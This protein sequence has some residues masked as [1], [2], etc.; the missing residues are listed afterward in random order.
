MTNKTVRTRF[1]P[2][3]TG[4]VHIGNFRTA[5]FAFLFARHNQGTFI[6]RIED[7]DQARL[8]EGALESLLTVLDQLGVHVD[9]GYYLQGG[10]VAEKGQHG[11]YLQSARLD[12][13]AKYGQELLDSGSAYYCFCTAE[14]LEEVRKEQMALKQPPMYD[15]HCRKLSAEQVTEQL[16]AFSKAGKKPVIRQAI[17]QEGS[18]TYDD[19]I[20]GKITIENS[21]LDDQVLLKSDGYPTYHM[22]VVIDDHLMEITHTIRGQEYL[23][24]TPKHV[25]LYDALGWEVPTFAH[26]PLIVNPDKTKLSKRQGDVAVEDYLTKGYLPQAL[27]N[28]VALLGWNPKTEQELFTMDELIQQFEISNVHK[29]P[30]VFDVNKLDWLNGLYIRHKSNAE[31]LSACK[32]YLKAQGLSLDGYSAEFLDAFINIEKDRLKKFADITDRTGFY[33]QAPE[34]DPSILVWKKS[35]SA[36]AKAKLTHLAEFLGSLDDG[37]Y[38]DMTALETKV[39][40]FIQASNYDN[41]SVLWPMRVALTG[42]EKSP[43]PFEV[44]SVLALGHGKAEVVKRL[45]NAVSQL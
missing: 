39:K 19:L 20:Y 23:S 18:V 32:P 21:I 45:Q 11:P 35:D 4:F 17:P 9:E 25:L 33:F 29:S 40:E 31:I 10:Q 27:V 38:Q 41:G 5:L 15:R 37:A 22:A 26:L 1:A 28:F 6:L 42:L 44:A 8:V 43:S 34:Y 7:T 30:A 13:Y 36:D 16:E 24:S 14:R 2:S 3:P 12:L